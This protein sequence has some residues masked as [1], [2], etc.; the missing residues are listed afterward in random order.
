MRFVEHPL[1]DLSVGKRL[2]AS[3]GRY[4]ILR[5]FVEV[6]VPPMPE[7]SSLLHQFSSLSKPKRH[8]GGDERAKN[9]RNYRNHSY[10][11]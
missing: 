7:L 11:E 10:L 1:L 5:A 8:Q 6:G 4:E 9:G 3:R 2:K